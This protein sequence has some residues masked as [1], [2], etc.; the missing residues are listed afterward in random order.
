MRD[1][2]QAQKNG[3]PVA[4]RR[5]RRFSFPSTGGHAVSRKAEW[6]P[7]LSLFLPALGTATRR[8]VH[9]IKKHEPVKKN[10]KNF[11]RKI[12]LKKNAKAP[13]PPRIAK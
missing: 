2:M 10:P 5:L 1:L 9:Y 13:R 12:G 8:Q 11:H 3:H 4:V 7:F 6:P